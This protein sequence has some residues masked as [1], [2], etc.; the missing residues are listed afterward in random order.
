MPKSIFLLH[1]C[2][3][4]S[5]ILPVYGFAGLSQI[6]S[7]SGTGSAGS[8]SG[9]R[10]TGGTG[11]AA[12]TGGTTSTSLPVLPVLDLA[13]LQRSALFRTIWFYT[14]A[15]NPNG[16]SIEQFG[17]LC[18]GYKALGSYPGAHEILIPF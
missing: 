4:S 8:P 6:T 7:T 5:F 18:V 1:H 10:G 13:E 2:Q 11:G 12:G 17:A 3:R 14:I 9:T 16:S 15:E